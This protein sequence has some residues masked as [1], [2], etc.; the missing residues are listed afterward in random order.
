MLWPED[1]DYATTRLAYTGT[2]LTLV[3]NFSIGDDILE[4]AT[5]RRPNTTPPD[6]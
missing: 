2:A 3:D 1:S 6:P 5:E 4:N